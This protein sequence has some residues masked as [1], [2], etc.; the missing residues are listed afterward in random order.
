MN[1]RGKHDYNACTY[2]GDSGTIFHAKS[3]TV[4]ANNRAG[5]MECKNDAL[6]AALAEKPQK[7]ATKKPPT[8]KPAPKKPA[9]RK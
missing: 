4:I 1:P 8:E 3:T 9:K 7:P 5:R 6:A 2:V